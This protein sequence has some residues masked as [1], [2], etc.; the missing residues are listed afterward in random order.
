MKGKISVWYLVLIVISV[1]VLLTIM[2]VVDTIVADLF[3]GA[4]ESAAE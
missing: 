3:I 2:Y 4:L 1:S